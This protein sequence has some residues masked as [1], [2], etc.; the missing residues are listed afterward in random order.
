MSDEQV[1]PDLV[2]ESTTVSHSNPRY[3]RI[4]PTNGTQTITLSNSSST[5]PVEFLTSPNACMNLSRSTIQFDVQL[6]DA[7]A[8]L[9]NVISANPLCLFQRIVVSLQSG[10]ILLDLNNVSKLGIAT[11]SAYS[12]FIETMNNTKGLVNLATTQ[13]VASLSPLDCIQRGDSNASTNVNIVGDTAIGDCVS[14]TPRMFIYG[15]TQHVPN[16]VS[17]QFQFGNAFKNTILGLDKLLYFQDNTLS[18]QFYFQNFDA[19]SWVC[20][21][22]TTSLTSGQASV[23]S[24]TVTNMILT[25]QQEA[26]YDLVK[27]V[28]ALAKSDKGIELPV[29]YVYSQKTNQ[30]GNSHS[31]QYQL[32]QGFGNSLNYVVYAPFQNNVAIG[33]KWINAFNNSINTI[34]RGATASIALLNYNTYLDQL[35]ISNAGQGFDVTHNEQWVANIKSINKSMILS[36]VDYANNFVH[37]DNYTASTLCNFDQTTQQGLSLKEPHI[38]SA[39]TNWAAS[40]NTNHFV[41]LYTNRILK[42]NSA[43]VQ[44][45]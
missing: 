6:G 2:Y 16:Y 37:F 30:T 29:G 15:A 4:A 36:C 9:T 17:Y 10:Q 38:Y 44:L 20:T 8:S 33:D 43:G 27:Q 14:Y 42:I 22:P 18:I 32:T 19:F 34:S 45:I 11:M 7:G 41:W 25:L 39:T 40:S 13:A 3:T 21:T 23:T 26:N 31:I 12:S 28:V 5:G 1:T 24:I 35:P